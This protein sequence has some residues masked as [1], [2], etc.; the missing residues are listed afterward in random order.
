MS[1]P[2]RCAAVFA[3]LMSLLAA[4]ASSAYAGTD[5]KIV[6]KGGLVEF[7]HLDEILLASDTNPSHKYGIRAYLDWKDS[8]GRHTAFVTN[9]SDYPEVSQNDLAIPEGTLVRLSACYIDGQGHVRRCSLSQNA[10]A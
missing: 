2:M 4:G 1:I 8:R 3:A 7:H 10:T 6:V 5:E 9:Y